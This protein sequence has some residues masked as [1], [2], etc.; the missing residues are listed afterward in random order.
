LLFGHRSRHSR[1]IAVSQEIQIAKYRPRV[2]LLH[3]TSARTIN[4]VYFYSAGGSDG[5]FRTASG[6]G[7]MPQI[8]GLDKHSLLNFC[9][10]ALPARFLYGTYMVTIK[11]IGIPEALEYT[12]E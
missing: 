1:S 11:Q 2:I 4:T 6:I 9:E 10:G 8:A 7:A 5:Q 12:Y 3:E